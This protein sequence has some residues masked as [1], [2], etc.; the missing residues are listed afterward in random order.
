[1]IF[2]SNS[3]KET[4]RVGYH[5][6]KIISDYS[7][8]ST[9]CSGW[10]TTGSNV[11]CLVGPLGSG[12]T[13]FVQGLVSGLKAR[14]YASSPTFKLINEY[15]GKIPVYHFDL[16]RL[17]GISDLKDLGYR[18]YFYGRGIT[19]IEWAEKIKSFWPK[20]CLGVYFSFF[21]V[22]ERKIKFIAFGERYEKILKKLSN[23]TD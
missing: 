20:E 14:P 17:Q 7:S 4:Y 5:L 6:G 21:G 13:I 10:A 2:K 1:M 8:F 15:Q 18:E 23:F 12:K 19:V 3:P 9:A 16:Y 11:V 22:K